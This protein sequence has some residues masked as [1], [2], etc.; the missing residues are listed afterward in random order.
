MEI[1]RGC[2]FVKLT[3]DELNISLLNGMGNYGVKT[4]ASERKDQYSFS[5]KGFRKH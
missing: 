1:Y 5:T 2:Y 4:E 3:S